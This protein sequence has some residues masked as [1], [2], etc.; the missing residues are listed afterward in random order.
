MKAKRIAVLSEEGSGGVAPV[1]VN[2]AVALA[3]G[4]RKVLLIDYDPLGRAGAALG[5]RGP[6]QAV[7]EYGATDLTLGLG[8]FSPVRDV[9]VPGLD[10]V[11]A[12]KALVELS[13]CFSP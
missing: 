4:G 12:T 7:A 9:T 6:G 11:P 5:V 8:P 2:M 13:E 3:Q 10:L 1:A